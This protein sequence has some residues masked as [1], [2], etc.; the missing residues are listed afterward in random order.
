MAKQGELKFQS[1][2]ETWTIPY[3]DIGDVQELNGTQHIRV[4]EEGNI[5]EIPVWQ[6]VHCS[7]VR[8]I[9]GNVFPDFSL[10]NDAIPTVYDSIFFDQG[11]TIWQNIRRKRDGTDILFNRLQQNTDPVETERLEWLSPWVILGLGELDQ[12]PYYYEE[13][14][15]YSNWYS[16]HNYDPITDDWGDKLTN[17]DINESKTLIPMVYSNEDW[18]W[19]H[20][21]LD[22]RLI[23][24]SSEPF[25]DEMITEFDTYPDKMCIS[26]AGNYVLCESVTMDIGNAV[27]LNNSDLVN[28]SVSLETQKS[29]G[30]SYAIPDGYDQGALINKYQNGWDYT[31]D[32][33]NGTVTAVTDRG[34][35]DGEECF[36][37][38]LYG[39]VPKIY[40]TREDPNDAFRDILEQRRID[41]GSVEWTVSF[42]EDVDGLVGG[43]DGV[44]VRLYGQMGI[45][46][47]D[48]SGN[49]VWENTNVNG[50]SDYLKLD[51]N[52]NYLYYAGDDYLGRIDLSTQTIDWEISL[53]DNYTDAI[54]LD[55]NDSYLY[56]SRTVP[57]ILEVDP[58]DGIVLRSYPENGGHITVPPPGDTTDPLAFATSV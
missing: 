57:A 25:G 1:E 47:Y 58:T 31:V 11:Y 39:T 21:V 3:Y 43:S 34:I 33:I 30:N 16:V 53:D 5:Y 15:T 9:F 35:A 49:L 24:G 2:R 51:N 14:P 48:R 45:K 20:H 29:L 13:I 55:Y 8:L 41:D 7:H 42:S 12:R 37:N 40:L 27:S 50:Y 26:R 23:K 4:G 22:L 44:Y 54:E 6:S 46:K 52:E 56:I 38:Y 17:I 32:H 18:D 19:D 10:S 36:V 28:P